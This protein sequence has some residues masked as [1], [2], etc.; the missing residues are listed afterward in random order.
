MMQSLKGK[1]STYMYK[2]TVALALIIIVSITIL[3]GMNE[4]RRAYDTAKGTF[5]QIEQIL[6]QNEK[7]LQ[8]ARTEYTQTCL[9]NA[10]AVAYLLE[11]NPEAKNNKEELQKIA[12]FIY[13]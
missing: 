10:N 7:E 9:N 1:I 13:L 2:I 4:Q 12:K 11:Q 5:K 3:D 8:Q 6:K